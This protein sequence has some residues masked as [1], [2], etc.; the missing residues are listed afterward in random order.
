MR[1]DA[2]QCDATGSLAIRLAKSR[3]NLA[4]DVYDVDHH[5]VVFVA[6]LQPPEGGCGPL[7]QREERIGGNNPTKAHTKLS[8]NL[9]HVVALGVDQ[10]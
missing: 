4:D 6:A 2:M 5:C 3:T 9:R 10:N 8:R 7:D 1:L